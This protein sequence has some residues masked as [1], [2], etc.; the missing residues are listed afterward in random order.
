LHNSSSVLTE[1][2]RALVNVSSMSSDP[3]RRT[4]G[5]RSSNPRPRRRLCG[6]LGPPCICVPSLE[7]L[8]FASATG[9]IRIRPYRISV[10]KHSMRCLFRQVHARRCNE[11]Q[12]KRD[13]GR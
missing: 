4:C 12:H 5:F 2:S 7:M 13:R 3:P 8:L 6:L 1:M 10:A 9:R 11:R